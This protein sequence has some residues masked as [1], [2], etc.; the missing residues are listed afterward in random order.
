MPDSV[1]FVGLCT[2][3]VIQLVDRVPA[4]N[5]KLTARRQTIAAGGPAANAAVTCS[6]LGGRATLLTG[7]GSHPL[8]AGIRQDLAA[9]GVQVRDVDSDRADSPTV[10]SIMV[11]QSTGERAVVSTN[12]AGRDVLVPDDL[13]ALIA[14]AAVVELD[15]HHP[16]LARAAAERADDNQ[17][18]LLDGGSW[19]PGTEDL[20]PYLDIAVCSADFH[21][22][23]VSG[24]RDTVKFLLD[25]GARY[26]AIS[27]GP[28]PI[29][30]RTWDDS[31]ETTVPAVEVAD[32]LG[33]G[34]VLHGAL[35]YALTRSRSLDTPIFVRALAFA[36]EVAAN[37]CASFGTRG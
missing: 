18:L 12:A 3:D 5:E 9:H 11:T 29:I 33:A 25:G 37:S 10:S 7:I 32:T 34:D 16:A 1:L 36:A 23:G 8:T 15:G 17:I 35:A 20:L 13:D 24:Q 31:G 2:L 30:W 14:D 22:P 26:A 21:P 28:E 6:D 27:N 4:A 19:K